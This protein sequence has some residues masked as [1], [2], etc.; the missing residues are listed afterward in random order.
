MFSYWNS[1]KKK[2]DTKLIAVAYSYMQL[3]PFEV[4]FSPKNVN[5]TKSIVQS[6]SKFECRLSEIEKILT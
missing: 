4:I 6:T 5:F 1:A 2:N 3:C